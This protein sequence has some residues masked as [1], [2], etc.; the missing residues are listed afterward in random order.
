MFPV[1]ILTFAAFA[2]RL[3]SAFSG[4]QVDRVN[5]SALAAIVSCSAVFFIN[6]HYQVA[7]FNTGTF[8]RYLSFQ[9][10][11]MLG[12]WIKKQPYKL[13]YLSNAWLTLSEYKIKPDWLGSDIGCRAPRISANPAFP[14]QHSSQQPVVHQ[15]L[16]QTNCNVTGQSP[17]FTLN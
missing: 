16:C 5:F 1:S 6:A 15:I 10:I 17:A 7:I 2:Y 8:S 9:I 4:T 14:S 3:A 12:F 13:L 11:L